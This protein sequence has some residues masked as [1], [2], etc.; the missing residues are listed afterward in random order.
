MTLMNEVRMNEVQDNATPP[1]LNVGLFEEFNLQD[2][3]ALS[4]LSTEKGYQPGDTIIQ[5]GDVCDGFYYIISG[6]AE[7]RK[8]LTGPLARRVGGYVPLE[9][10]GPD[11]YFGEMALLENTV[12]SASVVA[13]AETVCRVVP[14]WEFLTEIKYHPEM[15]MKLLV[16]LSRRLRRTSQAL[17]E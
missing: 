10:L 16:V 5:E 4:L 17:T 6:Q 13:L 8:R 9:V 3:N 7:V 11:E 12:R 2:L 1:F 14:S 15:A